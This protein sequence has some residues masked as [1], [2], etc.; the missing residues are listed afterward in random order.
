MQGEDGQATCSSRIAKT[1]SV[2]LRFSRETTQAP[3]RSAR[4]KVVVSTCRQALKLFHLP[5]PPRG[6][7]PARGNLGQDEEEEEATLVK[8]ETVK[9]FGA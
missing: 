9:T 2:S 8:E 5:Q 7:M 3:G 4:S 1:S 6:D